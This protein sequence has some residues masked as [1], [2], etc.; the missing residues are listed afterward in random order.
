M[1]GGRQ[2]SMTT[3][4]VA[5][6]RV[7]HLTPGVGLQIEGEAAFVAVK[8]LEVG[9]VAGAGQFVVATVGGCGRWLDANDVGAPI[10]E[11]TNGR[12]SGTS[13]RQ[14]EHPHIAE[15]QRRRLALNVGRGHTDQSGRTMV[16]TLSTTV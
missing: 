4:A 12:R 9:P 1:T 5:G 7:E 14:I 8:I 6:Q 15:R 10:G 3:S 16:K 2:F 13:N 11:L